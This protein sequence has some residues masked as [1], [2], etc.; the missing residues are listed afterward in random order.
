MKKYNLIL[1][2]C[3][4]S[5]C[6]MLYVPCAKAQQYNFTKYSVQEGLPQSVVFSICQDRRGYIWFATDGGGVSRFDGMSFKNFT[7]KDGLCNNSVRDIYED[8][9]GFLWFLTY[10][11]ISR[12]DGMQFT[13]YTEKDG[14]NTL[15]SFE[16]FADSEGDFWFNPYGKGISKLDFKDGTFE[17]YS[18]KNYSVKNGLLNDTVYEFCE[19][20]RGNLW[21]A[22]RGGISYILKG[23]EKT[24]NDNDTTSN[25][26]HHYTKDDNLSSNKVYTVME[27]KAGNLWFGTIDGGVCKI[28]AKD[29]PTKPG[30]VPAFINYTKKQGLGSDFVR[31]IFETRSGV[32]WFISSRTISKFEDDKIISYNLIK[33]GSTNRIEDIFEDNSG[34]LWIRTW[35]GGVFKYD[36]GTKTQITKDNTEMAFIQISDKNGL[37]D[38]DVRQ[39]FQDQAGN[40]WFAT[41]G[42]GVSKF[43]GETFIH[44]TENDL[45]GLKSV[46]AMCVDRSNDLWIGTNRGGIFRY[47]GSNFTNYTELDGLVNNSIGSMLEDHLGNMWFGTE[48]GFSK[49]SQGSKKKDGNLFSNYKIADRAIY[50]RVYAMFEDKR[51]NLWFG[52]FG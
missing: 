7:E 3:I 8:N 22:T 20:R 12:Y 38:N 11:G 26:F 45:Q 47:N 51:N 39:V 36:P 48:N 42:G 10:R 41:R 1:T 16:I 34:I 6:A 19:D 13:S 37:S 40:L 33:E 24:V 46:F 52:T 32:I 18:I 17:E 5:L 21:I 23:F 27:D 28:N 2:W 4:L 43:E 44:Y 14:L 31:R 29:I 9:S 49:F 30:Q 50:N 25:L 15:R 35:E